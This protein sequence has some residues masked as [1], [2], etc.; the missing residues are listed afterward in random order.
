VIALVRIRTM[1]PSDAEAVAQLN[2]QLGYPSTRDEVI[3]RLAAL[4]SPERDV[5]LV[6]EEDGRV[7][8]WAHVGLKHSLVEVPSAQVLGLVVAEDRRSAGIGLRLLE[9]AEGWALAHGVHRMLVGSR[10]TRQRAHAFYTRHGYRV[11][12]TSHIFEKGLGR[13]G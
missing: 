6:A 11:L 1:A 10:V 5:L 9:E 4:G 8:G 2:G 13:P 7:V 3:A 12:K